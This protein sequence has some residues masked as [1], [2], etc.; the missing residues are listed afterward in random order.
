[1]FLRF[2]YSRGADVGLVAE[3]HVLFEPFEQFVRQRYVALIRGCE[4]PFLKQPCPLV[5]A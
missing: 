3:H 5:R 4:R 2:G 1:M